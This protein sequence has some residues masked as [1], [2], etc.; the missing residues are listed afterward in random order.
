M[1]T[2][3]RHQ[4]YVSTDVLDALWIYAEASP[5][6]VD[7][8]GFPHLSTPD[9]KADEI[10]RSF[11]KEKYPQV[12]EHQKTVEKMKKDLLKTLQ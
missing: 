3:R 8:Q 12:K 4:I 7:D 10:L 5:S 1:S 6:R 11:F 2:P 9:E